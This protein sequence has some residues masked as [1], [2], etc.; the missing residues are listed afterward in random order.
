MPWG[1][2]EALPTPGGDFGGG[3]GGGHDWSPTESMRGAAGLAVVTPMASLPSV[4]RDVTIVA[5][6][7][8][9]TVAWSAPLSDGGSAIE[10]YT[11]TSLPDGR[12]C[13]SQG[14]SCTVTGL[15]N[16]RSYTFTVT[17][18]NAVGGSGD[19]IA[20]AEV[21]PLSPGFQAWATQ[22]VLAVNSSTTIRVAQASPNAVVSITGATN[23][24]VAVDAAGF[25]RLV[26]TPAKAG[27]QKFTA[28]YS[29]RVGKKT[30]KYTA[31]AQ[32]YVPA[33]MAPAM[34][35][36]SGKAGKFSL[37]FM[38]PGAS[39]LIALGDGRTLSGTADASGK[40]TFSPTFDTVGSVTFSV[41]VAGVAVSTGGLNV[42]K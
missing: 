33:V 2:Q 13:T 9:A 1:I 8:S 18:S 14:L 38:P 7:A 27:I 35:I 40:A 26:Y 22:N 16:R 30:T 42:S 20:S 5:G 15:T 32:L 12:T 31:T 28:T 4:P 23:S 19:S 36:K 41:S 34:K 24:S 25:A 29:A 17:A 21:T 39:I 3:G 11:A 6:V 37:Q 10:G